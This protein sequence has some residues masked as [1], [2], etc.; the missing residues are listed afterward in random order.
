M[1]PPIVRPNVLRYTQW[2][3]GLISA[4]QCRKLGVSPARMR[5]LVA[6]G[7]WRRVVHGVYDTEPDQRT[8]F[9]DER[10]KAAWTGLLAM[11]RDA[12]AVGSCALAL[13]GVAGLPVNLTPEVA[14]ADGRSVKGPTGVLVR[15]YRNV[16]VRIRHAGW[17]VSDVPTALVHAL[18]TLQRKHAVAVLDSALY[19][20]LITTDDLAEVRQRLRGRRGV[21]RLAP[22]WELVDGRAES[23]LETWARLDCHDHGF[24]PDDLQIVL[25]D[26]RGEIIG[27]GDMGWRRNDG[28][29]VIVEMDGSQVH[30]TPDALY[31]DRDR[32]NRLLTEA[33]AIVLRF[34]NADLRR[35]GAI[36]R[37]VRRALHAAPTG[38]LQPPTPPQVAG[39]IQPH[40]R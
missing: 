1:P 34:T 35:P 18:P 20:G 8:D 36:V 14:M 10:R 39:P 25:R 40:R 9:D 23:P 31:R 16:P 21:S 3:M 5:T 28:G 30:S 4:A 7:W 13:H 33:G 22:W 27:R 2:Q 6:R 11:G 24:P 19:K 32:Q 15:R 38:A 17:D 37:E 12:I 26:D 29:W